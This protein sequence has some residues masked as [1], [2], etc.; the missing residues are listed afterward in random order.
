ME[1]EKRKAA[2]LA[3]LASSDTDKSP[4]GTLDTPILP[5]INTLN[6][7]PCYFTTSS[8]S[9]RISILSQPIHQTQPNKKSKGGSWLFVSHDPADPDS[10][11]SLLFPDSPTR[12]QPQPES[13]LVLRFE[14]LIVAVECKDLASAQSLVSTARSTG[15]RESGITSANN[16][17]VIVAIRCSIRLEV[18]LG[19]TESVMVSPEFV[20]YLVRVAN[21]KM[22][23]N[24]IRTQGFLRALQNQQNAGVA[25]SESE[26][27]SEPE[28]DRDDEHSGAD[29]SVLRV[30]PIVVSGEEAVE[31]L[32]LWGHSACSLA[33]EKKVLVFGGFGGVGR[34]ARRNEALVLDPNSG[35]LEVIGGVEGS[36]SPS[37]RLGHSCCLVGDCA[38]VI[39]GR[40][41]PVNV[42]DDV[43]VLNRAKSGWRLAECGGSVFP[44]RH[45]HAAAVVGSKIYVFGGLDNDS[46]SSS[47][48]IL[49]TVNLKWEELVVGGERP[50]AR[51]SH[52]MVAYGCK[53]FMF[54]GYNG[55][56]ALGDLYSFDVQ[57]CQ[58]KKEKTAG[59][60]PHAR[61]SHSMFVYKDY[62]GVIGGCPVRQH[63][64]EL[65]LLDLRLQV[66]KYV[67]LDSVGKDLFVRSTANVIGDD[68]VLIG[69]GASCY[70]F[71]TKFSEPMKI[72]LLPLMTSN[73][74]FMPFKNGDVHGTRRNDGVT[75]NKNDSFQ[76]PQ[77]E[78]LQTLKE[79]LDLNFDSE[80]PGMNESQMIA[81]HW[82]LQLEK[83]Y[84]KL[85]KDI[86]KKFGWLDLER[87]VY[88]REDGKHICFPV[89]KKFCGVFHERQH[90]VFDASELDNDHLLKPLTGKGLLLSEISSL[91][92]LNLLKDC[93]A[94]KLVDEV[95]EVKR[96]AKSP[97]KVMGEAVAS[98]IKNRGL[99]EQLLEELPTRWERL[100]D[101][102]VLPVTSFKDP[103]WDSIG[104]EVWPIV[105]KSLNANRLARQGRVAPT[106]TRDSTLEILV[107]DNGWVDHRENGILYSF[108]ATKCMFS[109]GNLS[110]K[111]RMGH[112][113][114]KD[115]V[116]VDLFA[117][118]GYFVLPF[119]VRANAKLVY[120]CEW[121][122]NAIEA[123]QHNLQANSVSDRCIVL[124]GDNRITAP[125]GVADRVC[126]GLIPTSE[127]SWVTA[128]RALR[129]VGGMLHVHGNVKDSEEGLWTQHVS[130][131][132]FEIARSEG[133]CWEVSIEH[134]ER[135]KWYAP[136]IRHL[137]TDVR[138]R[139]AQR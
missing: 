66:W 85:G 38:F 120:A 96:A 75:G 98:L 132:I 12:S 106:G 108:N 33:S 47:F 122:P 3:S 101:I 100:G 81:S 138:C 89:T 59:R 110:E 57:T 9:G 79:D 111:L 11:I 114:C 109:W 90:H 126:L 29:L 123:L 104:A 52:S 21:E 19:T 13:E 69:G 46:I 63:C 28:P 26:S 40:G 44:P 118:I 32:Y 107:G 94:T 134:V 17:R 4:K 39:G 135:V 27:E 78:N 58:W 22:E 15:F 76:H 71:G 37:P 116:I 92:A 127:G 65:A 124:E 51:H 115:E 7:H 130:K 5:L 34:H 53:L 77:I 56:K 67:T 95:V 49:D 131:S 35:T 31:K 129:S 80:L 10:L 128:V 45:R 119:L 91:E 136:H 2:T 84:A 25:E 73:E 24:R 61:F 72:N 74:N 68:L 105:A 18:P 60:G 8:C 121:N 14:P 54:G 50:C 103:I 23:A 64:Q 88:S 42:L 48:H 62:L 36:G 83:K 97:L 55:D 41:D 102:V 70:A 99:S 87:K 6:N 93:G 1:F 125:K 137:V 139:P 133:Y 113:D 86:L 117:G 82:V 16:K 43:W 30:V 112:L 20:R